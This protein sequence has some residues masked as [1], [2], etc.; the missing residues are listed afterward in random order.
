MALISS[1]LKPV[2]NVIFQF[3]LPQDQEFV[4]HLSFLKQDYRQ[5]IHIQKFGLFFFIVNYKKFDQK[6]VITA[7]VQRVC[8]NRDARE[9]TFH[10]EMKLGHLIGSY[11]DYV[12]FERQY[13]PKIFTI[14]ILI[15]LS[16]LP[17]RHTVIHRMLTILKK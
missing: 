3:D 5:V 13:F 1:Y 11:S 15:Y 6:H 10:L 7:W 9:Y 12:R 4:T 8:P 16:V 14:C 2:F 17:F